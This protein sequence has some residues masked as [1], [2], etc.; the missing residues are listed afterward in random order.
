MK[1]NCLKISFDQISIEICFW[2]FFSTWLQYFQTNSNDI[3]YHIKNT[4]KCV[5]RQT[6]NYGE[7]RE[8]EKKTN[9]HTNELLR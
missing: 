7:M 6:T 5:L 4:H 3:I 9:R 2:F 8:M 1:K